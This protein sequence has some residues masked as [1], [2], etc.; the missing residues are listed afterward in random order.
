MLGSSSDSW[1]F[2]FAKR[3]TLFAARL[4]NMEILDFGCG[5]GRKMFLPCV[6]DCY[7]PGICPRV[8]PIN[9]LSMRPRLNTSRYSSK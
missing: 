2:I 9:A 5:V 4:L 3:A 8:P 7:P 1:T 6:A